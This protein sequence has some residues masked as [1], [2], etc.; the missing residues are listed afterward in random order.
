MPRVRRSAPTVDDFVVLDRAVEGGAF[1][2]LLADWL[3]G[4]HAT[5]HRKLVA[6]FGKFV[7]R[8]IL[9]RLTYD[10]CRIRAALEARWAAKRGR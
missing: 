8:P 5:A 3:W 6:R 1:D 7:G 4:A 10:L 2:D 9:S